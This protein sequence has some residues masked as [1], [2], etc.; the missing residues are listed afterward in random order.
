M[1][2]MRFGPVFLSIIVLL[3][4]GCLFDDGSSEGDKQPAE[5][6]LAPTGITADVSVPYEITLSWEDNADNEDGYVL[7]LSNRLPSNTTRWTFTDL[8]QPYYRFELF[9]F[10]DAGIS[11]SVWSEE[12]KVTWNYPHTYRIVNIDVEG[13][14]T[15]DK[16][17]PNGFVQV[18]E[19]S[20]SL[21]YTCIV[22][23]EEIEITQNSGR[24]M[25]HLTLTTK[26]AWHTS[27]LTS[28]NVP[29]KKSSIWAVRED[30]S[31]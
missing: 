3:S 4:P 27:Y 13:S 6:P 5:P 30:S 22:D 10:N 20:V 12:I 24:P 18:T 31:E 9:A 7:G 2:K 26:N 16:Q 17:T 19:D 14:S 1:K 15:N 25:P 8:E 28:G 21:S 23:G 11:S 29:P